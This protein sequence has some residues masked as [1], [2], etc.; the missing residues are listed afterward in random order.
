MFDNILRKVK[1]RL[2]EP[3]A[4]RLANTDPTSITL[5]GMIVGIASAV[6]AF[7][8]FYFWSLV[9]WLTNRSLDGLDGLVARIH[10]KQNDFGGYLDTMSDFVVYAALPI[11]VVLGLPS[12]DRYLALIGSLAIFYINT[13][14]WMYLSAI[15]EKL[16][17][18]NPETKTSIVMPES[19]IGG[20]ETIVIFSAFIVFPTQITLLLLTYSFLVIISIMQRLVWAKRNLDLSPTKGIINEEEHLSPQIYL[21]EY[22]EQ[23]DLTH[24]DNK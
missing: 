7:Y 16:A 11:G 3:I 2:L 19:L 20:F 6:L 5:I 17:A 18:R 23:T 8:G 9:L 13:A 15:L 21:K 24:Q 4:A 10:E 22:P 1:D 12:T 14:S